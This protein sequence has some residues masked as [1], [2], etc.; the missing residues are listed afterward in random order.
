M[1]NKLLFYNIV[2][3][4]SGVLGIITLG[5]FLVQVLFMGIKGDTLDPYLF[6]LAIS[7]GFIFVFIITLKLERKMQREWD[8]G[9]RY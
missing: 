7:F 2:S 9:I 1:K 4:V 5:I 6:M 8:K 3:I